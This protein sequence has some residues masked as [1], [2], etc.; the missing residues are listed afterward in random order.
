MRTSFS[1]VSAC[2][3]KIEL[4]QERPVIPAGVALLVVLC[5]IIGRAV[6]REGKIF[7][8]IVGP[9]TRR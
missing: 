5:P 7:D 9:K 2:G 8:D 6:R 3:Q 1:V 4:P